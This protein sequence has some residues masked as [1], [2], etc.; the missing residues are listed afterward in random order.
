VSEPTPAAPTPA[1][2]IQNKVFPGEL[3]G[4]FDDAVAQLG[5]GCPDTSNALKFLTALAQP[6]LGSLPHNRKTAI[7]AGVGDPRC[8]TSARATALN[9]LLNV[10][11]YPLVVVAVGAVLLERTVF[12]SHLN[13][14]I[15]L[16][17]V[18][19][20]L[21]A[22][23]RLRKGSHLPPPPER[24][25]NR[26]AW[27]GAV[28][29]LLLAPMVRKLTPLAT[30]GAVPVDGFRN[31]AFEDKIE[32]ERRYGEVY[33]LEERGSGLLLR[34]EFPRRVPRSATKDRLGIPDEMPDYEYDLSLRNGYFV[35]KGTVVD[36][37]LRKLAAVS[38]AF[39]P[40]F[41]TN[42]ELFKPVDAF[43]HRVRD[44][45]LEVVLLKR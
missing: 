34:F 10:I 3:P 18:I 32:R 4:S 1:P 17:V 24:R 33:S 44:K 16:G 38:P 25:T 19:A 27:Y 22:L 36:K 41:I 5:S 35:V 40:D 23:L 2:E 9:I 28:L 8:F 42:V 15:G 30:H 31:N 12:S 43:K 29:T 20:G 6:L 37:N 14:L 11:L 7:A 13:G 21:E 39:P 45:T 26:G